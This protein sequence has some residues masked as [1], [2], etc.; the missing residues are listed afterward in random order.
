MVPKTAPKAPV[1]SQST[2]ITC[3]HLAKGFCRYGNLCKFLH[4]DGSESSLPVKDTV[5]TEPTEAVCK[6][7]AVGWCRRGDQ[8]K[9]V[10][11]SASSNSL[12]TPAGSGERKR[13][14][15]QPL[16]EDKKEQ[17]R[18]AGLLDVCFRW[19]QG[20]CDNA[21]CRFS[22]RHLN[23]WESRLFED[24][25]DCNEASPTAMPREDISAPRESPEQTSPLQLESGLASSELSVSQTPMPLLQPESSSAWNDLGDPPASRPLLTLEPLPAENSCKLAAPRPPASF[26]RGVKVESSGSTILR[27]KLGD[28]RGRGAIDFSKESSARRV[29]EQPCVY[30]IPTAKSGNFRG[31]GQSAKTLKCDIIS[32]GNSRRPAIPAGPKIASRFPKSS[33]VLNPPGTRLKP[34]TAFPN[35]DFRCPVKEGSW[36]PSVFR[37][38]WAD[39]SDSSEEEEEPLACEMPPPPLKAGPNSDRRALTRLSRHAYKRYRKYAFWKVRKGYGQQ[40]PK[41]PRSCSKSS[42]DSRSVG[43]GWDS[44]SLLNLVDESAHQDRNGTR[45]GNR[46]PDNVADR[47]SQDHGPGKS[48][49]N[50]A[51]S[52]C[53]LRAVWSRV[54]VRSTGYSAPSQSVLAGPLDSAS[55]RAWPIPYP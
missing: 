18:Q 26:R 16:A 15:H 21:S 50:A 36:K 39:M 23:E 20:N 28:C 14:K 37:R 29:H 31:S 43:P 8:C 35:K 4:Q 9:F 42:S 27:H 53:I 6:H 32:G 3:P 52:R 54:A 38:A 7:F 51:V 19:A 44:L 47:G 40:R 49:D 22:H 25:L 13:V 55:L 30:A 48:Q 17:L 1:V 5:S 24:L 45:E 11:G 46:T 33:Y 10:H 12:E 2:G 34:A 41:N